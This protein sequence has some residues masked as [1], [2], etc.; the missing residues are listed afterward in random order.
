MTLFGDRSFKEVIGSNKVIKVQSDW[1]IY[2]KRKLG[3]KQPQR[4]D[5]GRQGMKLAVYTARREASEGTN[6]GN[7]LISD[8]QALEL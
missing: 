4:G 6:P 1:C 8:F 7:T 5:H 2:K 3:P